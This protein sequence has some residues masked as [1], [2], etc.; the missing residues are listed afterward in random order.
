MRP[1]LGSPFTNHDRN[2]GAANVRRVNQVSIDHV[3]SINLAQ[4]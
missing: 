4:R 2:L 3:R 1:D